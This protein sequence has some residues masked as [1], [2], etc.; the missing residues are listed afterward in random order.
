MLDPSAQKVAQRIADLI[1]IELNRIKSP[2]DRRE[3]LEEIDAD[4]RSF[5][6]TEEENA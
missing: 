1:R 3:F 5:L 4:L 6:D 2:D